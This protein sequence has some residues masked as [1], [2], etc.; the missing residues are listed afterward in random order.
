MSDRICKKCNISYPL[1]YENFCPNSKPRNGFRHTCRPC[2]RKAHKDWASQHE[3]ELKQKAKDRYYADPEKSKAANTAWRKKNP[4][5]SRARNRASWWRHREKRIAETIANQR[6]NKSAK[7]ARGHA[8]R[9]RLANAEGRFTK[10]EF[11]KVVKNQ[12]KKCFYCLSHL[13][14][15]IVEHVTPLSRGGSNKISNIVASCVSCNAQKYTKTL[16]EFRPDLVE[17]FKKFKQ[18]L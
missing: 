13:E 4:E 1:T 15:I 9:A 14:K 8:Y 18:L 2:A 6:K 7:A 17:V 5:K 11:D 16:E 3:E 10:E 12:D